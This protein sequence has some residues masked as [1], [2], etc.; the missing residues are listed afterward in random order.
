MPEHATPTEPDAT[1]MSLVAHTA[2]AEPDEAGTALGG[3]RFARIVDA[4]QAPP[5]PRGRKKPVAAT[6]AEPEDETP[7]AALERAAA[8]VRSGQVDAGLTRCHQTWP[9]VS[10][11]QDVVQMGICQYVMAL[12]YIHHG[13]YRA[14]LTAS[15]RGLELLRRADD[16]VR[17]LHMMSIHAIALVNLG[18]AAEALEMLYRGTQLL[19]AAHEDP[20]AQCRFWN[21]AAVVYAF[22]DLREEAEACAERCAALTPHFDNPPLKASAAA[23]LLIARLLVLRER[24]AGWDEIGVVCEALSREVDQAIQDGRPH[25]VLPMMVEASKAMMD[26]RRW[27][28]AGALLQRARQVLAAGGAGARLAWVELGLA[29]LRR[30]TGELR[31]ARAHAKE[32]LGMA[33]QEEDPMLKAAAHLENCLLLEAQGHWR[34]ALAAHREYAKLREAWLSGQ[35]RIRSDALAQRVA[36]ERQRS[37]ADM[38]QLGGNAPAGTPSDVDA[39]ALLDAATG[40]PGRQ[41]FERRIAQWQRAQ[42]Q[43]EPLVVMIGS[44]DELKALRAGLPAHRARE[45]LRAMGQLIR[46]HLRPHDAVAGWEEDEFVVGFGGGSSLQEALQAAQR[47]GDIVAKHDWAAFGVGEAVTVSFG[48]AAFGDGEDLGDALLRAAWALHDVRHQGRGQVRAIW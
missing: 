48:L 44:V 3:W 29:R 33:L 19:P 35:A 37:D 40:L 17:L 13:M 11:A 18:Q 6:P 25:L 27:D 23:N 42:P 47:L 28:D 1:E 41:A 43:G 39:A 46:S 31:L 20:L 34:S 10:Q 8:M 45:L 24:Q 30:E 22:L 21:H 26:A 38:A 14:A 9:L 36:V 7:A 32:A 4:M 16:H 5:S 12:G 2:E 15:H